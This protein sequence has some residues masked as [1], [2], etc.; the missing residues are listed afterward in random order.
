MNGYRWMLHIATVLLLLS[1]GCRRMPE[2][3]A[4]LDNELNAFAIRSQE[5]G[6]I[7]V[8]KTLIE[9]MSHLQ[10][11]SWRTYL[12]GKFEKIIFAARFETR[13][14]TRRRSQL[15]IFYDLSRMCADNASIRGGKA[16]DRFMLRLRRLERLRQEKVVADGLVGV[17]DGDTHLG[18]FVPSSRY[19]ESVGFNVDQACEDFEKDYN[20]VEM[21]K[22]SPEER[23][24][25]RKLFRDLM[26]REIRTEAQIK[27]DREKKIE[28]DRKIWKKIH[29]DGFD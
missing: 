29:P 20:L 10:E 27:I 9:K 11:E 7:A 25:I 17:D 2:E 28:E 1:L 6:A 14:F 23:V 5:G 26:G 12:Y 16:V 19:A 22:L 24:L 15:N 4:S 8:G 21:K 18:L 13:D 3:V